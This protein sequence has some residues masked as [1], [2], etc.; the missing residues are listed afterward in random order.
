[1]PSVLIT[2]A[3]RGIGLAIAQRLAGAG[4]NVYAGMRTPR[5]L[6]ERITPVKLD[7][8]NDDHIAE[9]SSLPS[10]DAVVNNAGIFVG[11]PVEVLDLDDVRHQLEVNVVAQV[12]VTQAV[13]P[14]LRPRRGRVVFI[15]SANGRLAVPMTG[16]YSASKFALTALADTM[17]I[18]L[19][20]W[21]IPVSLVEPG[22][23]D[24]DLW[25]DMDATINSTVGALKPEHRKLYARHIAGLR[26]A[27]P[28]MQRGT[29]PVDIVA[30]TVERALT[31]RRP[32]DR[33][34][35]GNDAR[36]QELLRKVLPTRAMDSILARA[37]G[38]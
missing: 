33:Y 32:R 10:L 7:L 19:R 9:L 20:P 16:A 27:A 2:G 35:V 11:G 38:I 28:K 5:S 24:T 15:S 6:G 22:A 31:D 23:I 29:A 8:T 4:W 13:L 14:L 25:R 36:V 34:V 30:A 18:E 37:F 1:M 3:G 26:K 21:H 17:R 12:A